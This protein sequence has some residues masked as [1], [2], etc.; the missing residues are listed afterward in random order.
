[1]KMYCFCALGN[2][3]S[4]FSFI[5]QYFPPFC[6]VVLSVVSMGLLSPDNIKWQIGYI[7]ISTE[8]FPILKMEW[9]K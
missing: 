9:A 6:P 7:S 1:M 2:T 3:F 4:L 5:G 8:G